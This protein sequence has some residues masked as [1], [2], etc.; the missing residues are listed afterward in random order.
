MTLDLTARYKQSTLT[1]TGK[2]WAVHHTVT[3]TP[4]A[5]LTASQEI[6]ELDSI[7]RFHREV[8]GFSVGIGY[9]VC[10]FP[11]GRSYR[12]GRASTQRAHILDRNHE[13]DGLC[14]VG[15][16]TRVAPSALALDEALRVIRASRMA[17]AGG[18]K[19]LAPVNYTECPGAWDLALLTGRTLP[20]DL[21]A[22]LTAADLGTLWMAIVP[23]LPSALRPGGVKQTPKPRRNNRRV[24]EIELP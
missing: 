18:H 23:G 6:A 5:T 22:P 20:E 24:I 7:D 4:S 14:F 21:S 8:R 1:H 15:N 11:S 19:S 17:V 13:F 3:A 16:F 10:V 2:R 12:V 9:H